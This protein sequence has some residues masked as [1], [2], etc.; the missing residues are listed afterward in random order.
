M[1][2]SSKNFR[3]G[4]TLIELALA[5]LLVGIGL[6]SLVALGRHAVRAALEVEDERRATAL[7]EDLF[8]TLR[9][10]SSTVYQEYGYDACLAFWHAVTNS[11]RDAIIDWIPVDQNWLLH[12]PSR[13]LIQNDAVNDEDFS[14]P[15]YHTEHTEEKAA[16]TVFRPWSPWFGSIWEARYNI[17]IELKNFH[18]DDLPPDVVS[19]TLYI[20]PRTTHLKTEAMQFTE[21]LTFFTHIPLEPLRQTLFS[22][23]K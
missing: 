14:F 16:D 19:V 21:Y 8:A 9:S 12:P 4:F 11:N 22:E 18:S 23:V 6:V 13:F 7:A 15:F 2:K 3:A 1:E 5:A 20:R 10:A 17:A